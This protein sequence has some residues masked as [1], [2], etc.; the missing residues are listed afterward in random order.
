MHGSGIVEELIHELEKVVRTNGG[1]RVTRVE[2]GVGKEAGFSREHFEEHFRHASNGTIPQ[3]AKKVLIQV[4]NCDQVV[5]NPFGVV[6]ASN[7]QF[8]AS[9]AG[10][11]PAGATGTF[12]VFVGP[13]FNLADPASQFLHPDKCLETTAAGT[14]VRGVGHGFLTDFGNPTLTLTGQSDVANFV[15]NDTLPPSFRK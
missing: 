11:L 8:A 12:Q 15:R 4:A 14:L 6:W 3:A 2:V 1:A 5:P 10:P 9:M 13:D 7:I